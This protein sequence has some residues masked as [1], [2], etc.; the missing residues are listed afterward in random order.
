VA[1]GVQPRVVSHDDD[2]DGD[3]Y[4]PI[5]LLPMTAGAAL[6]EDLRNAVIHMHTTAALDAKAISY[7]TG[8]PIRTVYSVLSTWKRTGQAKPARA[9]KEKRGRP[10]ALDFADT[11]VS[12]A[13]RRNEGTKSHLS[14]SSLS[15]LLDAI[16]IDI[17]R[18]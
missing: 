7:F 18:N 5:L 14:S 13:T 1:R 3:G 4:L 9:E 6:S 11:Q 2:D 8:V 17:S 15:V 16:T 10:R 12:L